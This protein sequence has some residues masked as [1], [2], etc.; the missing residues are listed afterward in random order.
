MTRAEAET[1]IRWDRE[2]D[3]ALLYT[4]DP[5]EARRWRALGYDV[6]EAQTRGW[7]ATVPISAIALL[8]LKSGQVQVPR[9]LEP[10]IVAKD[11]V[12]KAAGARDVEKARDNIE[13]NA[14]D[15]PDADGTS[16][17]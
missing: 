17:G 6:V 7:Q 8:K 15:F 11:R 9:W 4:A 10:P 12:L 16:A 1:I 3:M 14:L 5:S 13:Q 2:S